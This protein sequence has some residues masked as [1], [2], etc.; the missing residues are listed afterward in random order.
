M[1]YR[2]YLLLAIAVFTQDTIAQ[3]SVE[4]DLQNKYFLARN[5]FKKWFVTVGSNPGNSL[6]FDMIRIRGNELATKFRTES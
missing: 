5:R 1:K 3:S 4:A 2:I 6:P